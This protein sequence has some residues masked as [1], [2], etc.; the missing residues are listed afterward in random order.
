M[1]YRY[2]RSAETVYESVRL[3]LD[4]SWGLPA[5]GQQTCVPVA[6]VA[7]RNASGMCLLAVPVEFCEYEA[8]AAMLPQL[9][10]SGAVE[11]IAASEYQPV[12]PPMA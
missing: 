10:E 4:A 5:D 8:V 3:A 2:F 12:A 7:P 1:T 9:L 6:G 11:E